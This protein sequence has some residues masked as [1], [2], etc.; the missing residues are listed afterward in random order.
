MISWPFLCFPFFYFIPCFLLLIFLWRVG[1]TVEVGNFDPK[2]AT[3]WIESGNGFFLLSLQAPCVWI[4]S[5]LVGRCLHACICVNLLVHAFAC[6]ILIANNVITWYRTGKL[7]GVLLESGSP[8]VIATTF[9]H[10][11][12]V[13]KNL[14]LKLFVI[15]YSGLLYGKLAKP[16]FIFYL[17]LWMHWEEHDNIVC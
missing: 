5:E 11:S 4:I 8:E 15:T 12:L 2:I 7:K 9:Q 6:L 14:Y 13:I 16:L 1:E 10:S 3:F 17:Y